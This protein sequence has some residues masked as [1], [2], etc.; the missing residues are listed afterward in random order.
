[1]CFKSLMVKTNI[2]REIKLSIRKVSSKFKLTSSR[3]A[4][5]LSCNNYCFRKCV[6]RSMYLYKNLI[7]IKEKVTKNAFN[8]L[9]IKSFMHN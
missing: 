3:F 1:M 8:N 7:Q 5:N 2:L 6:I 9:F 4:V